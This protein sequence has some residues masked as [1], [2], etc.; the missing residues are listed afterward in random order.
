MILDMNSY[1]N[2]NLL[3]L[4]LKTNEFSYNVLK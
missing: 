2:D 4:I 3:C 1:Y